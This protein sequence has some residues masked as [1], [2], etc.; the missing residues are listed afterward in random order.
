MSHQIAVDTAP[1][2]QTQ[3]SSEP[4]VRGARTPEVVL[5]RHWSP[6]ALSFFIHQG[7]IRRRLKLLG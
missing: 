1:H 2:P 5:R 7:G 6:T 3:R 4:T